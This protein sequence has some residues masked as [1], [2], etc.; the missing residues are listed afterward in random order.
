M[1]NVSRFLLHLFI[2]RK[3]LVQLGNQDFKTQNELENI[4]R[5]LM[6]VTNIYEASRPCRARPV[7][8][9]RATAVDPAKIAVLMEHT[10]N[11]EEQTTK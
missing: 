5:S 11:W 9:P 8:S 2:L 1:I 10:S 6:Y 4:L 3:I 7:P